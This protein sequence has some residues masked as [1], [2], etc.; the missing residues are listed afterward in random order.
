MVVPVSN[1]SLNF[2]KAASSV[3]S[4]NRGAIADSRFLQDNYGPGCYDILLTGLEHGDYRVR[5]ETVLLFSR[6]GI[7][8][9]AEIIERMSERDRDTV[10]GACIAYGSAIRDADERI[11]DLLYAVNHRS[12]TEYRNAMRALGSVACAEQIP[13]IRKVMGQTEGEMREQAREALSRIIDRD[14]DLEPKRMFVLS[15]PV[16]PN[17]RA[18]RAFLAKSLDYLDVRYR[19]RVAPRREVKLKT[20]NDVVSGILT[21][22]LR[23][24]NE[25]LNYSYYSED[26][27]GL[28]DRISELIGWAAEDLKT[29]RVIKPEDTGRTSRISDYQ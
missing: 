18:Y 11:P 9:P 15:D 14:P 12:G 19:E 20:Y 24:Y 4:G 28:A 10:V 26:I 29:K 16:P 25:R 7:R 5:A 13:E 3:V 1:Y 21:M 22:Q 17:E 27:P 8:K 6:L 23:M 2:S